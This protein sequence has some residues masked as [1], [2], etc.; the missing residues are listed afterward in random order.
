MNALLQIIIVCPDQR[1]AEIPRVFTERIVIDAESKGCLLYTSNSRGLMQRF[2][3]L[4]VA[5]RQNDL[6]FEVREYLKSHPNAAV[7]NLGCG[8]ED[9]YKR[10]ASRSWP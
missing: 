2:G 8:L 5:M 6:A 10:Q 4:E 3:S 9:V 7:V 1:V